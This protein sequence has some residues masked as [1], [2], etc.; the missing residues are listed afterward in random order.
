M[1]QDKKFYFKLF[2]STFYLS[3]FTFGGGFVIIPLMRKKFVEEYGWI[4]E[5][6]MLDLTAIAQSSPGAIAIN[7][8]ILVGYR[9]AGLA[10]AMI[11][12]LGT[13]LPPLLILSVLSVAYTEIQH[14]LVVKYILRGM[15]AG[16]A[17]VIMD[18]VVSLVRGLFK[19]KKTVPIVV[20]CSA[21]I[22]VFIFNIDVIYIILMSGVVG[23]LDMLFQKTGKKGGEP[24]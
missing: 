4:D 9:L 15:Q 21:F 13:V 3:A 1:K 8:A 19:K 18:V 2:I 7:A 23:G 11:T 24:K 10:G 12:V 5:K 22:A 20:M 6:E 16:V 17:A 14:N